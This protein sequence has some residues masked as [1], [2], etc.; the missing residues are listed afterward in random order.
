[1]L[2]FEANMKAFKNEV[3]SAIPILY[4]SYWTNRSKGEKD[5][6]TNALKETITRTEDDLRIARSQFN[7]VQSLIGNL[8]VQSDDIA[9]RIPILNDE[10]KAREQ[11]LLKLAENN[12]A[13]RHKV[14]FW[15]SALSTLAVVCKVAPVYQPALGAIGA[16]LDV[17]SNIDSNDPVDTGMQIVNLAD[18]FN[19]TAFNKSYE[20]TK[21]FINTIDPSKAV[22][23]GKQYLKDLLPLAKKLQDSLRAVQETTKQ[24]EA[25]RDRG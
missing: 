3:D 1:M 2:S 14:P 23:N 20:Q 24:S 12:V 18:S 6:T 25:P 4:L 16:G 11:E 7:D 15:K 5:A 17:A 22:Q 9:K 19:S 10:L 8:Q 21:T 13:E